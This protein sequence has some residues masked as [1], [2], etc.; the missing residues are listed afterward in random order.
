M[1][2]H[3]DGGTPLGFARGGGWWRAGGD[4]SDAGNSWPLLDPVDVGAGVALQIT[5]AGLG[6]PPPAEPEEVER[7]AAA[8]PSPGW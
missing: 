7:Q 4:G 3:G 8:G 2:E 6:Q 1:F 5:D